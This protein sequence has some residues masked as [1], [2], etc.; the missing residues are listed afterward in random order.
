[1]ILSKEYAQMRFKLLQMGVPKKATPQ[2]PPGSNHVTV[3]DGEGN[4]ATIIHSC[5][6]LPWSNG[7]FVR[8]VTIV[9]GGAHFFRIMPKPGY[10]ATTYVAP[11]I[12]YK[13]KKP[14][15][16]SGSPSV[17]LLANII[18][19]TTNIL[20]FGIPIDESVRLGLTTAKAGGSSERTV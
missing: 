16:A 1:M 2:L 10:R 12:L 7:L 5:M 14:I 11:N 13:N 19:N 15:L 17:G 9:A 6:S 4:V 18:Q 3:V 8:G 20:D